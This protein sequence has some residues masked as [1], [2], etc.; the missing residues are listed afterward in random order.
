[1]D[2]VSAEA[3]ETLTGE[4]VLKPPLLAGILVSIAHALQG[5]PSHRV[6]QPGNYDDLHQFKKREGKGSFIC[7][8]NPREHWLHVPALVVVAS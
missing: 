3:P 5:D 2:H 4:R 8:S 1:M 7:A 6:S